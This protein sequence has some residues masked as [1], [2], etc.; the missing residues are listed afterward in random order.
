[1]TAASADYFRTLRIALLQGRPFNEGDRDGTERVAIIS[2]AA[3][4]ILFKDRNP[5]GRRIQ[6]R[7]ND[8]WLTIIGVAADIRHGGLDQAVWPELF[9]PYPQAP[10]RDMS[11]VVRGDS[12]PSGLAPAIRKA[13][14]AIDREQPVFGVKTVETLLS[15]SVA[16]RRQRAWLLGA[17]AFLSLVVAM[18]GVYGVMAYSVTQRTHEIGVRMALGAERDD[19]LA[20]VVGEGLV[21]ALIGVAIG[22]ALSLVLTRVLASFLFG[23]GPHDVVTFASVSVALVAAAYFAS[24]IPARRATRID[25]IRALRHE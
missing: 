18:V 15:N 12:D 3:A 6:D 23:V 24:Y 5:L 22:L 2:Q 17:F 7:N 25:P 16:Q 4:R 21:L 1:V 14:Q 9:Q 8:N 20:M 13:I 11:L 19:V 10:V